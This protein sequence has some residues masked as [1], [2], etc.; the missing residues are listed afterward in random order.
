MSNVIA[1]LFFLF[2]CIANSFGRMEY[3]EPKTDTAQST[4]V[5]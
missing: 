2:K 1:T 4:N 5:L 3:V